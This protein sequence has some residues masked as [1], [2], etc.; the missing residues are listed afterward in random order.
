MIG[1]RSESVFGATFRWF[2]PKKCEIIFVSIISWFVLLS[3]K[4]DIA[5][6]FETSGLFQMI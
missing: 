6:G 5:Q 1:Y 2:E 3:R 4:A